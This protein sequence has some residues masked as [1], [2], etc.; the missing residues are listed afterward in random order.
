MKSVKQEKNEVVPLSTVLY[1]KLSENLDSV[2]Q[3]QTEEIFTLI[4][5]LIRA[6]RKAICK[7]IRAHKMYSVCFPS[8][9]LKC[10]Q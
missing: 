1:C 6:E 4:E 9:L 2:S 5:D 3:G 8:V 10:T 7:Q